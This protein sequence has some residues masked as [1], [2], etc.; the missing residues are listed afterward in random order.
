MKMIGSL[1]RQADLGTID[2]KNSKYKY[3]HYI[4]GLMLS[5][6]I[7]LHLA[8]HLV[9]LMGP[10]KH[11]A[12][13]EQMRVIYRNVWVESLLLLAVLL[14]IISGAKL[15]IQFK[16][17]RGDFFE[18][19][20]IQSGL[21]LAFFLFVHVSAVLGGRLDFELDTNFYF[22]AAG[23]N[24]FPVNLFFVPYYA[25]GIMAFFAH[26]AAIHASKM[27]RQL[28]SLSPRQQAFAILLVGALV[29]LGVLY[30]FTGAFRGMDIPLEYDLF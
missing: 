27:K 21:Y 1:P 5:L 12:L 10:Q 2:M 9:A 22:G 24:T 4:T 8:N 18:R 23:L 17:Q 26:I 3:C 15:Y 13:M 29:T 14:Q 6:F 30:G 25:L 16:A 11:I 28:F 20:H 19:L 7:G